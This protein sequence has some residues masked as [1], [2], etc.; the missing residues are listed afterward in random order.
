MEVGR[1]FTRL[2]GEV[3]NLSEEATGISIV[4]AYYGPDELAPVRQAK[5][6]DYGGLIHD[7]TALA[8]RIKDEVVQPLRSTYLA[9][10]V[11]SLL[12]VTRW[13]SGEDMSY[14]DLVKHV[15]GIEASRF[16]ESEIAGAI[17]EVE[18]AFSEYPGEDTRER[19]ERFDLDG[20]IRGDEAKQYIEG[21]MQQNAKD[22]SN[23]FRT[24]VYDI[25][26]ASVTDN[27]VEYKA[28]KDK[29]W[30]GYNYYQGNYKSLNEFNVDRP[31]SRHQLASVIYH[32]YEHHVSNLWREKAYR[33]NHWTDLSIVPLTGRCVISEGTADTAIDFLD[34]GEGT[35]DARRSRALSNLSRMCSMNAALMLNHENASADDVVD[36]IVERTFKKEE[37][38]RPSLE[39]Y[40]PRAKDGKPNL[41]APYIFNYLIGRK[42]FVYP[43]FL[44]AR[45]NEVLPE[46]FRTV[47]LN[48]YSGSSRTWDAAFDWL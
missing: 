40:Q 26:G 7:L 8:D 2:C 11:H 16:S 33:E 36:Y 42:D 19:V 35:D 38:V 22:V 21:E 31:F 48:P 47:Y 3:G 43:T 5:G 9:S 20:Q 29:P 30:G 14:V 46:F 32:E 39:F 17:K 45:E 28:V 25:M 15:F 13:I 10:E 37:R 44:K 18:N 41:W 24:K 6:R 1:E 12:S 34:V 23:L 4:D 27:G